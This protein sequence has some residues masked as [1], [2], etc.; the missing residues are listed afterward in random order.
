M[1]FF[2]MQ[3]KALQNGVH[4]KVLLPNYLQVKKY[5]PYFKRFMIPLRNMMV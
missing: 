2:D 4:T 3:Q 1:Y 5:F